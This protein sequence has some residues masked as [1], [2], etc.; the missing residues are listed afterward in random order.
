[1]VVERAVFFHRSFLA[2]FAGLLLALAYCQIVKGA[3]YRQQSVQNSIR[4]VPLPGPR[5]AIFDRNGEPLAVDRLAFHVALVGQELES[6]ESA[7]RA[8][9]PIVGRSPAALVAEYRRNYTAPFAP[10]PVVKDVSKE[11]ALQAA[12]RSIEIPGVT[13]QAVPQ[14]EYPLGRLASHCIGYVG[15]ID[16]PLLTRWRRYGYRIKDLVGRKGLEAS[17]DSYLQGVDGG[18]QLLVDHRARMVRPLGDR[19]ARPGQA[20][21]LTINAGLQRY[22]AEQMEGQTG[23]AV[24]MDVE[25]GAVWAMVSSPSFNP[26]KPAEVLRMAGS[27]LLN[28]AVQGLYPPGSIF[29]IVTALAALESR[30]VSPATEYLCRGSDMVG[31]QRFGCWFESGHG[32]VSLR[33]ALIVSCNVFFIRSGILAG[34]EAI[35]RMALEFGYGQLTGIELWDEQ[36]GLSPSPSW[37]RSRLKQLWYEGDTANLSI[38]QG[39]LQVTPVQTVQMVAA[40]ANG[41]R[42]VHPRLIE[43]IGELPAARVAWRRV[44]VSQETLRVV[45]RSLRGVVTDEQGTGKRAADAPVAIAGKTGTAQASGGTET[46]AWFVG[47]CPAEKPRFAFTVLVE[48]GGHG[49]NLPV[50]IAKGLVGYLH[51]EGAI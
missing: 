11:L 10:T 24:V 42:L 45:Q 1:M 43:R 8:L 3:W 49:G 37:K 20:V 41:G 38:G 7:C 39:F 44:P 34:A 32:A 28:R 26:H 25:D 15:E 35:A 33:R 23:A 17:L 51:E 50:L 29:K 12:E 36:R 18:R 40:V 9:A 46:H 16:Q 27:P 6:L 19:A 30:R 14:R 22:L 47:F 2:V 48:H 4:L 5:G 21:R 13:I 31:R